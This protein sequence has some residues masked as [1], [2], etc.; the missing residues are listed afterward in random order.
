MSRLTEL[1]SNN[2]LKFLFLL[3]GLH[4]VPN[5]VFDIIKVYIIS[6]NVLDFAFDKVRMHKYI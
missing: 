4:N 1:N 6:T 2:C 5:H 3:A